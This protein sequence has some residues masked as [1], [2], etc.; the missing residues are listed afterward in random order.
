MEFVSYEI[1]RVIASKDGVDVSK[2]DAVLWKIRII[3]N[4]V[5]QVDLSGRSHI[6]KSA[7]WL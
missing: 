5:A 1:E 7:L 6:P 4:Q 3:A 2:Q